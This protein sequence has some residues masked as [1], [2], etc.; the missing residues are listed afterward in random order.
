[1]ICKRRNATDRKEAATSIAENMSRLLLTVHS[2]YPSDNYI[3]EIKQFVE[4]VIRVGRLAQDVVES[5]NSNAKM[6]E[7]FAKLESASGDLD[8]IIRIPIVT[9]LLNK[10]DMFPGH[11]RNASRVNAN[12]ASIRAHAMPATDLSMTPTSAF[13]T[14]PASGVNAAIS[15]LSSADSAPS[16]GPA[17]KMPAAAAAANEHS[18]MSAAVGVNAAHATHAIPAAS[19]IPASESSIM[20]MVGVH[21]NASSAPLTNAN[22]SSAPLMNAKQVSIAT[23]N[24][25]LQEA[26][27]VLNSISAYRKNRKIDQHN[28]TS[29]EQ[30]AIQVRALA[31]EVMT[32]NNSTR[33]DR[34]LQLEDMRNR[35]VTLRG[36]VTMQA[37]MPADGIMNASATGAAMAIESSGNWNK[38]APGKW[39][40]KGGRRTKRKQTKRNRNRKQTKRNRKRTHRKNK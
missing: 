16:M 12:H 14:I 36:I 1:V 19:M 39:V 8:K 5:N 40:K 27:D 35:F 20:P 9:E 21:A 32:V 37:T 10:Y 26:I 7:K 22:A 3:N 13:S 18:A 23:A 33:P 24:K 38:K 28:V 11:L 25:A 15:G 34:I 30:I 2:E 4:Q 6:N 29:L 17:M 31:K